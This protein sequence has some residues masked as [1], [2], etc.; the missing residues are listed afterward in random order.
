M[1]GTRTWRDTPAGPFGIA[2]LQLP[3]RAGT[4]WLIPSRGS[5]SNLI[6]D[7]SANNPAAVD[8]AGPGAE[9]DP[10]SGSFFIPNATPDG[11]LS[12]PYNSLFTLFGQF[13]DH[14][15]DLVG[16]SG[17]ESVVVPLQPD[18]PLYVDGASH[19]TS[20]SSAGRSCNA[21]RQATNTTTPY[22]DQNQTYT[23]H[24]SHQ[25]FLREY[26]PMG[27]VPGARRNGTPRRR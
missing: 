8:A 9:P 20:W 6:V 24:P 13:F 7:Q 18:D 27:R 26:E 2:S 12:A 10:G 14:G 5:I 11:G 4:M 15:L 3:D 25:V 21:R 22:V 19:R 16:K 23:S 1:S 17:T